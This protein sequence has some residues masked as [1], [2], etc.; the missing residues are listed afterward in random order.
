MVTLN[1][2]LAVMK[3]KKK[4]Y[5]S[6]A[7]DI[8]QSYSPTRSAYNTS[9]IGHCRIKHCFREK[10]MF[11]RFLNTALWLL[12]QFQTIFFF[13]KKV[14]FKTQMQSFG[15]NGF[16]QLTQ[17]WISN[18]C[19]KCIATESVSIQLEQ[20]GHMHFFIICLLNK[21]TKAI[22]HWTVTTTAENYSSI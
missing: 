2:A 1:Y 20:G 12:S 21:Q 5:W 19:Q 16:Y 6:T 4:L 13:L 14:Y 11:W 17:N 8:S 10:K 15:L 18:F 7:P 3:S 22:I 9:I